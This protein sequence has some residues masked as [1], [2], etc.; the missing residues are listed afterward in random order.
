MEPGA[1][2]LQ[3]LQE[4]LLTQIVDIQNEVAQNLKPLPV[5]ASSHLNLEKDLPGS[6]TANVGLL[7]DKIIPLDMPITFAMPGDNLSFTVP[8]ETVALILANANGAI[9]QIIDLVAKPFG[10]IESSPVT[11]Q[12][13]NAFVT[14]ARILNYRT[15]DFVPVLIPQV[16]PFPHTM[17]TSISGDD[18]TVTLTTSVLGDD[19]AAL[20]MK[21]PE[22]L[23]IRQ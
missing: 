2:F 3:A 4:K 16:I 23:L 21:L 22:I 6:I 12:I 20:G 17:G 7:K 19:V 1:E 15:E 5:Y 11:I 9:K 13:L 14:E 10:A 18:I 8:A